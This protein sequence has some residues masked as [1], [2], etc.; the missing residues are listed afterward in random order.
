MA[1]TENKKVP[2]ALIAIVAVIVAVAVF[3]PTVYMP[4]KNKKPIMD[5]EHQE[6]MSTI[7]Y[8]EES[9][10]HKDDIKKDIDE[11]TK[12][13]EEFQKDM[14][15][16]ANSSLEDLQK[17][18][19]EKGINVTNFTRS[20]ETPDEEGKYSFTGCPLYYVS[21]QIAGYASRDDLLEFL[22]FVE[23]ESVGCYYVKTLSAFTVTSDVDMGKFSVKKDDLQISMD[24]YL[25]YYNQDPALKVEIATETD[26]ETES[27]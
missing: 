4:Y 12:Q 22:K 15:V 8:Y 9:I 7:D 14:F 18:I 1:K 23:Q 5:S 19:D 20:A 25:Y 16:D 11:L 21:L 6:A 10:S 27:E 13:W 24:I 2:G 3:V 17:A 26:T